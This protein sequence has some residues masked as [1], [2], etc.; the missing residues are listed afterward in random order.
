MPRPRKSARELELSGAFKHN[1]KRAR[2]D[3]EGAGP[4]DLRP[5]EHLPPRMHE[6]WNYVVDRL[7]KITL[8]RSEEM[9]VESTVRIYYRFKNA[10]DKTEEFRRLAQSLLAHLSALGMTVASRAKLGEPVNARKENP[11]GKLREKRDAARSA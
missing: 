5:P 7:P 2:R 4:S 10:D 8:S 11:F 1:P 3:L 6:T 9:M